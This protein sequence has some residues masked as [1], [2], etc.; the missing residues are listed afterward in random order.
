[1]PERRAYDLVVYK[2]PRRDKNGKDITGDK[3]GAGGRHRG[4]GTYSGVA[5]DPEILDREAERRLSGP[6]RYEDLSPVGQIFV[7]GFEIAFT[8]LMDY[9]SNRIL[10]EFDNWLY[11][12]QQ[13]KE[14]KQRTE[15]KKS[16]GKG[17]KAY[18]KNGEHSSRRESK[19]TT[20]VNTSR[21]NT[22]IMPDEFD[23]AYEQY[24]ANMTSEE[25][26]KELLDAFILYVLA[27]KKLN[28]VA[29]AKITDLDE[30]IIDGRTMID[31]ISAPV[32]IEKINNILDHN[33][34]LLEEWQTIALSDILGGTLTK[35]DKLI[36]INGDKLQQGLLHQN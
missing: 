27:I 8:R 18:A 33:P 32:V 7:D 35:E 3:V 26:Q 29:R 14:E 23:F 22:I 19:K 9:A 21:R 17:K 12:R 20:S 13:K 10:E 24:S 31:K 5:Y 25:A 30:N 16:N 15:E 28:K 11:N 1:M 36:P 2:V 4:D 6:V 34:K